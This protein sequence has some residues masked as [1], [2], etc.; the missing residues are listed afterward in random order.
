MDPTQ[1]NFGSGSALLGGGVSD[2]LQR[3]L[4]QHAAGNTGATSAVSPSSQNYQPMPQQTQAPQQGA[5]PMAPSGGAQDM[6][7]GGNPR[8]FEDQLVI[9]TLAQRLKDNHSLRKTMMENPQ[10]NS[11]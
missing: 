11:A 4:A 2:A 10:L 6:S 1:L 3:Q 5:H 8:D 9:K 7:T